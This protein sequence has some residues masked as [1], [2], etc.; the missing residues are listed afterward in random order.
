MFSSPLFYLKNLIPY[1][2]EIHLSQSLTEKQTETE[3]YQTILKIEGSFKEEK[4]PLCLYPCV[5]VFEFHGPL[6]FLNAEQ[7]KKRFQQLILNPIKAQLEEI[8][9]VT[10]MNAIFTKTNDYQMIDL[11]SKLHKSNLGEIMKSHTISIRSVVFDCDRVTYLDIKGVNVLLEMASELNKLDS[12][13]LL[14]ASCSDI[15]QKTLVKHKFFDKFTSKQ[16]F[17]TVEDAVTA[18]MCTTVNLL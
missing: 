6:I 3:I 16:C 1:S 12:A 2:S 14:L 15:V 18:A 7:F 5:T 10:P 8:A 9:V 11:R 17:V 4:L 13:Q